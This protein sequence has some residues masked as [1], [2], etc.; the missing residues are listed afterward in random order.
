MS[1]MLLGRIRADVIWAKTATF[2]TQ[3]TTDTAFSLYISN[4]KK[5]S[6]VVEVNLRPSSTWLDNH[7]ILLSSSFLW[8]SQISITVYSSTYKHLQ[9][10]TITFRQVARVV[11]S[12]SS[13]LVCCVKQMLIKTFSL[14]IHIHPVFL[15]GLR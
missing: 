11:T 3:N 4:E 2:S 13:F 6:N 7:C 8:I 1:W 5:S 14:H 9:C 12:F 15:V 10:F